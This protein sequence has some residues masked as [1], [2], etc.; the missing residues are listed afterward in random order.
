MFRR[1]C[2][3]RS[4]GQALVEFALAATLIFTLLAAAVDLGLIFFTMQS[5][6]TAA[7][8]GANFGS[9]PR[10]VTNNDGAITEVRLDYDNIVNRVR[11]SAGDPSTGF[12]DM[13]DLNN[14]NNDDES[15]SGVLN[16]NN[17]NAF[18]YIENPR[19]ANGNLSNTP[20]ACPTTTPHQGM[21]N[22]GQYCYVRVTVSYNYRFFFP[23]APV[24]SD[25]IRLRATHMMQIRSTF[26]G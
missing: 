8:E 16:Y 7:Q 3:K 23:L 18:I 20:T 9:Y 6:R 15:D 11:A 4:S 1:N 24:F 10:I 17:S 19:F 21:R 26:I 22:A 13:Y 5:L 12:V 14:N 2:S 25:T